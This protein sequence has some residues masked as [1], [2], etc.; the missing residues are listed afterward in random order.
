MFTPATPVRRIPSASYLKDALKIL[1][2]NIVVV[3]IISYFL[4]FK[5]SFN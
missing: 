1:L 4:P 5:N 3:W 2:K